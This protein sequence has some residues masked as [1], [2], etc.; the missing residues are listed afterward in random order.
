MRRVAI[1]LV[2][3]G[4]AAV[5]TLIVVRIATYDGR[6]PM[7]KLEAKFEA[8]KPVP[9]SLRS[10]PSLLP[11]P[12]SLPIPNRSQPRAVVPDGAVAIRICRYH[13]FGTDTVRS[14]EQQEKLASKGGIVG[15]PL[16]PEIVRE[17][18]AS[19]RR[20]GS[21]SIACPADGGERM[22]A[23]FEYRGEPPVP[24][25][26]NLSGCRFAA[27]PGRPPVK[28]SKRLLRDL[29]FSTGEGTASVVAPEGSG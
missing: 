10:C 29:A 17:L 28:L 9:V 18:R 11:R 15:S 13:G 24:L 21:G 5:A 19:E 7:E 22:L 27:A 2:C 26:V 6:S 4:M 16:V 1:G 12:G 20:V 3:L 14:F 8:G 25:V 23:I